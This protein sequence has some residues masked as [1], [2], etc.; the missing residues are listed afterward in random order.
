[1]NE[2]Y[3]LHSETAKKLYF[4]YARELPIVNISSHEPTDKIYNNVAAVSYTHLTL[5]T[6]AV[7]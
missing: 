5:P 7:V 2:N 6:M 1:M 3:L 4:E